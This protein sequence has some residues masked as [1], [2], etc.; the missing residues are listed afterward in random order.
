MGLH[1]DIPMT[2]LSEDLRRRIIEARQAGAGSVEV[3]ERFRVSRRTVA[4]LYKQFERIGDLRPKQ[5]G[6]YRRSKLEKHGR[7]IGR[8]ISRKADISLAELKERCLTDLGIAIGINALW[9]QL[10]RLGLSSKKNDVRRRAG[11]A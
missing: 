6:G 2:P 8:W 9:H 4:R 5:I 7:T 11:P 3:S 10:H 1:G